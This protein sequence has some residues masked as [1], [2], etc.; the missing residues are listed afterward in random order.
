ME[1]HAGGHTKLQAK[2]GWVTAPNY[3]QTTGATRTSTNW[4]AG[5]H[6]ALCCEPPAPPHSMDERRRLTSSD[7]RVSSRTASPAAAVTDSE[8]R[9]GASRDSRAA[10][11]GAKS[12]RR[13]EGASSAGGGSAGRA[14]SAEGWGRRR[15]HKLASWHTAALPVDRLEQ[16][17]PGPLSASAA[18]AGPA[19]RRCG[20]PAG[21]RRWPP[22]RRCPTAPAPC[23]RRRRG[24]G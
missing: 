5:L 9:S 12:A 15:C 11:I 21:G 8:L 2:R 23:P 22:G 3:M 16:G 17:T 24:R 1:E 19:H 14:G 6:E 18:L 10:A 4:L 7:W 13:R 20:C